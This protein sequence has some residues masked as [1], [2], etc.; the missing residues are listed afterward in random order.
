M[1]Q[2]KM[3]TPKQLLNHFLEA[4]QLGWSVHTILCFFELGLLVGCIC[5]ESHN[6]LIFIP[7]F[8]NLLNLSVFNCI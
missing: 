1:L 8:Q 7:S 2:S 5:L 3:M 6:Y 4:K